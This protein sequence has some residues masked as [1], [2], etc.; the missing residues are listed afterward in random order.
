VY[1]RLVTSID[2]AKAHHECGGPGVGAIGMCLTGGFALAMAV[3]P[4]V[5]AP[6]VS[7]PGLPAPVTAAKRSSVGLDPAD[8]TVIKAHPRVG[9]ACSDCGSRPTGA[10]QPSGSSG[11]GTS[12]APPSR[13]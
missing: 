10:A 6:V 3:D 11:C 7:Q 12:W 8:L 5:L 2:T 4:P 13:P 1:E 9:C